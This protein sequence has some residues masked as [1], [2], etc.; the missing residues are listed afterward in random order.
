MARKAF[1]QTIYVTGKKIGCCTGCNCRP[2]KTNYVGNGDASKIWNK[3]HKKTEKGE[4]QVCDVQRSLAEKPEIVLSRLEHKMAIGIL[5][6]EEIAD[7]INKLCDGK[8]ESDFKIAEI[9]MKADRDMTAT[10]KKELH[11]KLNMDK[12]KFSRYVEIGRREPELKPFKKQLPEGYS[13]IHAIARMGVVERTEA[14]EAGII[15]PKMTRS[16]LKAWFAKRAGKEESNPNERRT[17]GSVFIN[18]KS[19][20]RARLDKLCDAL[21]TICDEYDCE[22]NLLCRPTDKECAEEDKRRKRYIVREVRSRIAA[23][24]RERFAGKKKLTEAQKYRLWSY[25]SDKTYLDGNSDESDAERVLDIV[26]RG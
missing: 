19:F 21:W 2:E 7:E 8:K 16:Q 24:K 18:P 12:F 4:R 3:R 11:A 15:N 6:A 10:Q 17:L 5:Y 23:T 9:A 20:T 25:S 1:C 13:L 14:V 26:G 22:I